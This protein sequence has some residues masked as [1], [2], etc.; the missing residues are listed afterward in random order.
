MLT[1][2]RV[3]FLFDLD[4]TLFDNDRFAAE[5]SARLEQGFGVAGRDRYWV[6]YAKLRDE[7]GCA[8]TLQACRAGFGDHPDPLQMSAFCLKPV[9]GASDHGFRA[10]RPLC[11]VIREHRD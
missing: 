2:S 8:G 3:V 1:P 4:N 5:W 7:L 9:L 11:R 6:R 10:P